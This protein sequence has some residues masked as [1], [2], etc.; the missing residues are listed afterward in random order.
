MIFSSAISFTPLVKFRLQLHNDNQLY[1]KSKKLQLQKALF[2]VFRKK[3]CTFWVQSL[4]LSET[5]EAT[6]QAKQDSSAKLLLKG[7]VSE[8][9]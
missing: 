3:D 8:A 9:D 5:Y 1:L 2:L 4:G 7:A 6:H